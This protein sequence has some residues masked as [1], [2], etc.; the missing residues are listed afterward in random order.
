[1]ARSRRRISLAA[2]VL[3]VAPAAAVA[4]GALACNSIVGLSDFERGECPG[5]RCDVGQFDGGVDAG[6]DADLDARADVTRGA[7]P[8]S[9]ARWEMP[10]YSYAGPDGSVLP[11]QP[12][13]TI[14]GET[15]SAKFTRLTWRRAPLDGDFTLEDARAACEALTEDG[16]WRLPKRIELVTLLDYGRPKPHIDTD[17]FRV[18]NVRVWSSS[19]VRPF[20]GGPE[21]K[22]WHVNFDNG[23]VDVQEAKHSAKALCVRGQ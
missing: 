3:V 11:R 7:D 4:L 22:Y 20:V 12:E 14:A 1:M 21:Q 6:A 2:V 17:A 9:W 8:V 16:P 18:A 15:V 23:A 10:N 19:E 5:A 13:Y